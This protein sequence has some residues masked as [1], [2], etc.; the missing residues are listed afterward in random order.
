MG[1][2]MA[3]W[4]AVIGLLASGRVALATEVPG[5]QQDPNVIADVIQDPMQPHP[6][7][8]EGAA[9]AAAIAAE[10]TTNLNAMQVV[11]A[12]NV[13]TPVQIQP[14]GVETPA[15]PK[16]GPTP[17][18]VE[19]LKNSTTAWDDL[20]GLGRGGVGP[21][22][23]WVASDIYTSYT[24]PDGTVVSVFPSGQ[25]SIWFQM[26]DGSTINASY[27]NGHLDYLLIALPD[28]SSST[29]RPSP[30]QPGAIQIGPDEWII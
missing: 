3:A 1:Q 19:I 4:I 24:Y 7:V 21:P 27:T 10:N 16:K 12:S 26:A 18:Q 28:G 13:I 17:E 11:N 6:A 25:T 5:T 15:A 29:Y 22:E 20:Q 2:K 9:V 23:V 14:L 30:S 8:A